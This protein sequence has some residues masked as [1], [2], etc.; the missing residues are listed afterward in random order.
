MVII[1]LLGI[2]AFSA[3]PRFLNKSVIDIKIQ[4][5]QLASDIRYAQS[6]SL[7]QGI[8]YCIDFDTAGARY[9]LRSGSTC[10][11]AVNHPATGNSNYIQL[12]N[13][14]MS[15][16]NISGSYIQFDGRGEPFTFL[17]P[18]SDASIRLSASGSFRD[19]LVSPK[20]GRVIIQ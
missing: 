17:I 6:Q 18:S 8:R 4:A 14:S 2:L 11:T 5:E 19:I 16:T 1:T 10:A 15:A 20:T 3:I 9:R 7:T 12:T 13:V